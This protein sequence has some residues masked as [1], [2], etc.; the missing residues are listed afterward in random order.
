M[1]LHKKRI[2]DFVLFIEKPQSY[3]S[4]L[5]AIAEDFMYTVFYVGGEFLQAIGDIEI[6]LWDL[7]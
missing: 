7:K 2:K 3:E 4:I 1:N 5:N 6:L